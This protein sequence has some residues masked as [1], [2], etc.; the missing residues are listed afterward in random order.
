MARPQLPAPSMRAAQAIICVR[1]S[2]VLGRNPNFCGISSRTCRS[3]FGA[4][5]L[6]LYSPPTLKAASRSEMRPYNLMR[7]EAFLTIA[8]RIPAARG[9]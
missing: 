5:D 2:A 7:M 6:P 8:D 1:V 4:Q 9:E 3:Y